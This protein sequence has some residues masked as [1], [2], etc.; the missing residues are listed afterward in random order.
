MSLKNKKIEMKNGFTLIETLVTMLLVGLASSAF[1]L[2]LTQAKLNLESIRIKD[3]AHQELKLYT[4]SEVGKF[5]EIF[6]RA[7]VVPV[8]L[9]QYTNPRAFLQDCSIRECVLVGANNGIKWILFESQ[10]S[11]YGR[12]SSA[13][14]SGIIT[15]SIPDLDASDANC[16]KP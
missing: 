9:T 3:Q 13:G 1:L 2:G 10:I 14:T 12:A 16:S 6:D 15:P 8:T 11:R 5:L 4:E 7:P